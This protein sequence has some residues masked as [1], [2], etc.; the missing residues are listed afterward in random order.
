MNNIFQ[1]TSLTVFS[2]ALFLVF[3]QAVCAQSDED[4]VKSQP[5]FES[6]DLLTVRIEA[7]L[8]TLLK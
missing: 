1:H 6:H 4:G 3:S 2:A 5:L 8:T 7:P